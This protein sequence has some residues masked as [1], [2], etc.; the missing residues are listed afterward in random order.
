M[1]ERTAALRRHPPTGRTKREELIKEFRVGEILDAAR[2]VIGRHGFEGTTI[3]RVAEEA[4]VAKGTIYL[5]F[6]NKD[7]LL[8]AAVLEGLRGLAA[9]SYQGDRPESAPL[10]RITNFVRDQFRIQSSHQDFL[11][12]FILESSFVTFE[13]GDERGE[14]LRHL[15][16]EYLDF[17]A[18]MLRAAIDAG[19]LRPVDPQLTAF[20]LTEMITG[21][22][23]RRLM[24]LGSTP[25]ES[26]ADAVLELFLNG[27]R[28]VR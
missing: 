11:K 9:E 2:H 14:E 27:V 5:Y 15:Y 18:S 4:K 25:P 19:A 1:A 6:D 21:C 12:A 20:I 3:D 13:P 28:A 24:N 7:D 23:R 26:D 17:I 10:E 16:A 22:L 8:H